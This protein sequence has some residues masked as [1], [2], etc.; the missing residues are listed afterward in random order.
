MPSICEL[1]LSPQGSAPQKLYKD[2]T[3]KILENFDTPTAAAANKR[4]DRSPE[5]GQKLRGNRTTKSWLVSQ[6]QF[7]TGL[8]SSV[9]R[10][11]KIRFLPEVQL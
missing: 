6:R 10:D 2:K 3:D 8:R 5:E 7:G 9:Q 4:H 11:P 1:P